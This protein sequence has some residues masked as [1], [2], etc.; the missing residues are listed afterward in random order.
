MYDQT[1]RIAAKTMNKAMEKIDE[2]TNIMSTFGKIGLDRF[3]YIIPLEISRDVRQ[4]LDQAGINW[5]LAKSD[6]ESHD[7]TIFIPERYR[8]KR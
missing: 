4:L 8:K 2:I 7:I 1:G 3:T 6:E 5:K